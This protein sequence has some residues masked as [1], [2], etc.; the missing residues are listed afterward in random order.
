MKKKG[1]DLV[2]S[3]DTTGSM[4]SAL[5]QLRR[6]VQASVRK[7]FKEIPD[8]RVGV[9]AHGDYYDSLVPDSYVTKSLDLTTDVDKICEFVQKADK[10]WGG[11]APECYE[12]VLHEAR[13]LKWTAGRAKAF[14]LIGDDVPHGPEYTERV[15]SHTIGNTKKLDWR[16]EIDML[17]QM[18][19]NVYGVQA[20]NR[21]HAT[22]FYE[23]I[24]S[25]SGGFHLELDQFAY[26][27]DLLSAI[28]YKQ[29]GPAALQAFEA[30]L[31]KSGR[32][33][34]N[35]ERSINKLL[36]K[37]SK[38]SRYKS[39]NGLDTVSP[40]RFQVLNVD[41]DVP[42]AKFVSENGVTFDPGR[43]FYQFT[44]RVLVQ[45]HK[46]VVLR[47]NS[48]GDLFS[49][50][51]ARKMLGLPPLGTEAV[52]ISPTSL[53]GYT[54]FIQ[55]TSFNRKLLGGTEFLYEVSDYTS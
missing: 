43:G 51:K 5:T 34:R 42:I 28:A 39:L 54:A 22:K 38:K 23:E 55:S 48:S 10:T 49:G 6:N 19:V 47:D 8:L 17:Q 45:N 18:N 24:A 20:L 11:D 52:K 44:K 21:K 25:K 16:N 50:A 3:F 15:G 27:T 4:Y 37:K 46:E 26:V 29:D 32:M 1:I 36:G 41:R 13:S 9:I 12:L 31:V 2:I 53:P 30:D 35:V 7:L 40:G 33:N 14:V